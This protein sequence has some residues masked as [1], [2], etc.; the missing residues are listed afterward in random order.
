MTAY[1][2]Y[3]KSDN[4]QIVCIP[5]HWDEE[6]IKVSYSEIHNLSTTGNEEMLSVSHIT[7][8]TPRSQKNVNMFKSETNIGEK[9]CQPGDI[10]INTMWAWMAAMGV[11]FY[12]GIVSP[13]YGV[14][15]PKSKGYNPHYLDLL[16]R[17]ESYRAEYI[18]NSTGIQES[19]LRLYPDKFLSMKFIKPPIYE[20]NR[21]VAYLDWKN[22]QINSLIDAQNKETVLM[23]E[24]RQA[25]INHEFNRDS[26]KHERKRFIEC[27]S[28]GRGLNITKADLSTS[29]VPCISYGQ[30]H[31]K[32]GFEVKPEKGGLPFVPKSYLETS[33]NSL[34]RKDDFIF[35]DTSEDAKGCGN[36]TY[37]NS[38]EMAFAGYHSIIAHPIYN[39]VPRFVAY[40]FMSS[41][42]REQIYKQVNEVKVYSITQDILKSTT[43]FLPSL[44]EQNNIT[45]K[46]DAQCAKIDACLAAITRETALLQ[47]Y[48]TRLIAD[49]VTG[50]VD[51]QNWKAP[52]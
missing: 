4:P 29:G 27:F 41:S 6:R 26:I 18:R 1:P 43:L 37:L 39:F 42:F 34:V 7:G 21:I 13:S 38:N 12:N 10:V 46:L 40:Y 2:K 33:P 17:T 52:K 11:S 15:R 51:V 8:I 24:L 36:F 50:K 30:I 44:P 25:I 35:A 23:V 49:V 31:G 45:L 47:E 19:R 5:E 48:R 9:I 32:F 14:Y 28:F 20:Q 3:K 22:G 16:L